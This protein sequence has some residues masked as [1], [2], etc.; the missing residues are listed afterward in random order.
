MANSRW[1][2]PAEGASTD[3]ID[4]RTLA[5]SVSYIITGGFTGEIQV[6]YSNNESESKGTDYVTDS[7]SHTADDGPSEIPFG[8]ARFVQF[9]LVTLTGGSPVISFALGKGWNGQPV[10][11]AK[12]GTTNIPSGSF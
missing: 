4:L 5:G 8:V 11:V 2:L 1:S 6:R 12:H 7:T 10:N 3:W 9:Y